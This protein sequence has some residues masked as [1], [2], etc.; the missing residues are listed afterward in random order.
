MA[1]NPSATFRPHLSKML[2]AGYK[3]EDINQINDCENI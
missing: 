3:L 1:K 2:S